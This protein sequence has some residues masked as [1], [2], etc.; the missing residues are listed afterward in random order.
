MT[1]DK[2]QSSEEL[3]LFAADTHASR[4]A[5]PGSEEAQKMTATSG[6]RCL[7]LSNGKGPLGLLEKT[8]L[9]TFQWA[10]TRCFLTWKA[11]ATPQ[12]RL[13]YQLAPRTP[14]TDETESGLWPTPTRRDYK[15]GRKPETLAKSG[16]GATNSLSDA[17]TVNQEYGQLNPEWVEFL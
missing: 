13:L 14:S 7:Q 17:L 15:G 8:L 4:S 5:Q 12:G 3:T 2:S 11:K 6:Q 9:D 16:R 10:S 1:L